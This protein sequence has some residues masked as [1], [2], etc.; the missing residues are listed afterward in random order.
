MCHGGRLLA[1]FVAGTESRPDVPPEVEPFLTT[2]VDGDWVVW[3]HKVA[4][5]AGAEFMPLTGRPCYPVDAIAECKYQR[6]HR[7]PQ[8]HCTCGFHAVSVDSIRG[9]GGLVA[10]DV[11]LSGRV[12]A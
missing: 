11:A 2:T 12:L 6:Q 7:A 5:R 8:P 1:D 3:A 10:L 4:R 9:L